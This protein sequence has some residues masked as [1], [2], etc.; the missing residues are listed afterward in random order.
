MPSPVTHA[1][2]ETIALAE[3]FEGAT[4][5]NP[6]VGAAVLGPHGE[7]MAIAAHELAGE[8]HAEA[9]LLE[10]VRA[11][12]RVETLFVTLEPCNHF[13]KTPPCV[14]AILKVRPKEV[15]IGTRDPN[16][17][18][19]GGGA[20]RLE[21]N[22]IAVK[23]L[24]GEL[25]RRCADLI[26]PFKKWSETQRPWVTL[27]TV[28]NS[29]GSM[30]PPEGQK[31]F[32]SEAALVFAHTLR[33]RSGAILTGSGTV[34]ADWPLFTVRKIPDH[35][36]MPKR[37]LGVLDRR[38]RLK[39]SAARVW[40]EGRSQNFNVRV[41]ADLNEMIR[42]FG[43][44]GVH[45]ILIEAGPELSK[46]ARESADEEVEIRVG[47]DGLTVIKTIRCSQAS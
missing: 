35:S 28:F 26:A 30:I 1:F 32:S 27:K 39:S 33:K 3:S 23:W 24:E 45:R 37:W 38:G 47:S 11:H 22:G 25:A 15:V 20:R 10:K 17:K 14:D 31:T 2:F 12:R 43:A 36:R 5:P 41:G 8:A 13:G 7:I 4:W 42:F 29:M 19:Q 16:P 40:V 44:E 9:Q 6:P 34:L 46:S 21:E 18:V